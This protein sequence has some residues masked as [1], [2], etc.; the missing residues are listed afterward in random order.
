MLRLDH[1]IDQLSLTEHSN[2][3]S[4]DVSPTAHS[5]P[6]TPCHQR[7]IGSVDYT[8]PQ[9]GFFEGLLGCL[10][11]VWTMIGKAAVA[12]MKKDS[13]GKALLF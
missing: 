12:E 6:V 9:G 3:S 8:A 10:R 1:D 11:P 7:H 4:S 13:S 2:S 5:A